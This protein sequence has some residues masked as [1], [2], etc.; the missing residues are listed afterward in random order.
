MEPLPPSSHRW[1]GRAATVHHCTVLAH[2]ASSIRAIFGRAIASA[3]SVVSPWS[4]SVTSTA[5]LPL[6]LTGAWSSPLQVGRRRG[7]I[8]LPRLRPPNRYMVPR[9]DPL[10]SIG[11]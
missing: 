4:S 7:K 11:S 3:E 1:C 2:V 5:L 8:A 9:V 10:V 6:W